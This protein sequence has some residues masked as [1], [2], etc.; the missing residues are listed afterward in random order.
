[1]VEKG[2]ETKCEEDSIGEG[3]SNKDEVQCKQLCTKHQKC[4][5]VYRN[6]NGLCIL[7]ETCN[8]RKTSN[9]AAKLFRKTR[10]TL[11]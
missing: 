6:D 3:I 1:M 8:T 11:K 5:F 2:A 4:N 9:E 10:G 7:W